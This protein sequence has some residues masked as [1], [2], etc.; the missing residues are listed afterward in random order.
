M[1]KLASTRAAERPAELLSKVTRDLYAEAYSEGQ[2]LSVYLETLDPSHEH[3]NTR[4]DA[5]GRL[6]QR[7]GLVTTSRPELGLRA[8]T[9][10]DF[11]K[12][13]EGANA[14]IPELMAR[15]W[16]RA[17]FNAQANRAIYLSQDSPQG[18]IL[19]PFAFSA[20]PRLPQLAPAIPLSELVA[21]NTGIDRRTY[22][23]FY[24]QH[25]AAQTRM[26]R[27]TEAAN[28]PKAKLVSSEREIRLYKYGRA[29]QVSYETLR[30]T[31][32]DLLAYHIQRVA[33]QAEIDKV[34]AVVDV[35]I[36]GDGN[37]NTSAAVHTLSSLDSTAPATT[38]TLKA[39]LKFKKKFKNPYILTTLLAQEDPILQ[40]ELLN[41]GSA[42]LPLVS[43]PNNVAG[44]ITPINQDATGVRYGWTDET[45]TNKY[46][47]FDRRVTVER[48]FEIA[49]SI[50]EVSRW[51]EN[52]TQTLTMTESEGY[53]IIDN[54]GAKILDLT[55]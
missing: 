37:A 39:W 54:L 12:H 1:L 14:L 26:V 44:S 49:A 48:I 3:K 17:S 40:L 47:G 27:V 22:T 5:F 15:M 16:R 51:I 13:G 19:N 30:S 20:T 45:P 24:L 46:V 21:F 7:A 18:T 35:I 55:A 9:L 23:T 28:I 4:L 52:Q 42:N 43:L 33:I 31:P 32:I 29:L 38:L 11:E 25:D 8:A 10:E 53:G 2:N 36:N 41:T 34:A 50:Q 6:L